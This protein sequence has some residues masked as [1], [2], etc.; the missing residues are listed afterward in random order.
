LNFNA[1]LSDEDVHRAIK[2]PCDAN[3]FAQANYEG[4]R[5]AHVFWVSYLRPQLEGLVNLSDR[6]AAIKQSLVRIAGLLATLRTLAHQSHFQS[7]SA[8]ARTIFELGLDIELIAKDQSAEPVERIKAFKDAAR[9]ARA[10]KILEFYDSNPTLPPGMAIEPLRKACNNP[11]YVGPIEANVVKY[12]KKNKDG[13]LNWPLHWSRFR[14]ARSRAREIG[15]PWEERYIKHYTALSWHVHSGP[16][17]VD[18]RRNESFEIFAAQAYEFAAD[19]AVD[20]YAVAGRELKLDVAMQDWVL[21]LA[22]L[23]RVRGFKLEDNRLI[24]IGEPARFLYLEPGEIWPNETAAQA[25]GA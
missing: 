10:R 22:F 25:A 6:E 20:A 1:T 7:I 24:S 2:I 8:A 13:D 5:A 11:A 18:G 16:A 14:G 9:L 17:G 15:L 12:W 19:V 4:V 23:R 21:R 3:L